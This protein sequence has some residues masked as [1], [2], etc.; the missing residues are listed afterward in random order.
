MRRLLTKNRSKANEKGAADGRAAANREQVEIATGRLVLRPFEPADAA[1][2]RRLADN[3]AVSRTTLN[4]PH[5]YPPGT[6]EKWIAGQRRSWELR[7]SAS[8]AITLAENGMLLGTITLSWINR[9]LAELGYWIGEPH[10]N[11]GYCSE[12]TRALIEFAFANFEFSKIIAEHLQANPASGR[13][14]QKAGMRHAGSRRKKD[15]DGN[16]ARMEIYEIRRPAA[17]PR[18]E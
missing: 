1:A 11:R 3:R 5:P 4:L 8:Y 12:A 10:W 7:S 14:M 17:Q 9:T 13:V 2:V 18:G 6:A 15:R 16:P